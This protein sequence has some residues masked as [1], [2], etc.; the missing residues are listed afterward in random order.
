MGEVHAPVRQVAS[1]GRIVERDVLER[2]AGEPPSLFVGWPAA[3][4]QALAHPA[5]VFRIND[6]HHVGKILRRGANH[7]GAAYVDV[8]QRLL[9]RGAG[10]GDGLDERVQVVDHDVD[11]ADA[12]P[13][14][15]VRV[16]RQVAARENA[17]MHGWVKRLHAAVQNLREPGH[18]RHLL[19]P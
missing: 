17:A 14:Q 16:L 11:G 6:D 2:L 13:F 9:Q 18:V 3:G 10:L 15:L 5:V 7:R 19:H 1:D 8:L 12:V 4:L